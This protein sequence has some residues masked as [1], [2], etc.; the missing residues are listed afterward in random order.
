LA[1]ASGFIQ[2]KPRKINA[3]NLLS[4]ICEAGLTGSPSCND[5]ASYIDANND[6]APSKQA[7]A[8]R[9]NAPFE[10]FVGFLL[11]YVISQKADLCAAAGMFSSGAFRGY[12]RVLVQDSTVIMLPISL[13]PVF[14]GV[15]N[16]S[17]SVCNA[18]I[19]AVY[20][21]M[22]GRLLAFSI[23]PYSRN[24]LSA[25]P[26]LEIYEG[27]LVL[28]DR[29]YLITDE[30]Q[31]H[32]D[33]GADCIYRHKTGFVYLDVETRQPV[34]LAAQLRKRGRLDMEV[35]LNNEAQTRVRLVA[36]PVDKETANKRRMK[37]KK[38]AKGHNPSQA[39]LYLMSWTIFITTIPKSKATFDQ[40]LAIYGLRWRIEVIFKA[41]KSH[42]KFHVVHQAS[43]IQLKILLK[44]R[45]LVIAACASTLYGICGRIILANHGRRLSLLKF[46]KYLSNPSNIIRVVRSVSGTQEEMRSIHKALAKYCC[47]DKR[48]RLNYLEMWD[49]LA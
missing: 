48:R 38:E 30:L 39:V 22:N 44:A 37:A 29:G 24:D 45:L 26:D 4:S 13:F 23:D 16:A 14:S 11:E 15:A 10:T 40:I 21:L 12:R 28:R 3:F 25:A 36:A 1:K 49:L 8:K 32:R 33:V 17:T 31:R 41:W 46:M 2:R 34:N 27:D 35:L 6:K 42:S 18:R 20:D 7:V 19:Q 9:L 5:L 43:E 47:Y